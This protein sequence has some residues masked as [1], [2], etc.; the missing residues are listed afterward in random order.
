MIL[1]IRKPVKIERPDLLQHLQFFIQNHAEVS[2][3]N[4]LY[5]DEDDRDVSNS[6]SR[7]S[8]R[9]LIQLNLIEE[10]GI[11]K[12]A[13]LPSTARTETATIRALREMRLNRKAV[14]P[15]P[16]LKVLLCGCYNIQHHFS[17]LSLELLQTIVYYVAGIKPISQKK[18]SWLGA[19]LGSSFASFSRKQ[20]QASEDRETIVTVLNQSKGVHSSSSNHRPCLKSLQSAPQIIIDESKEDKKPYQGNT[21]EKDSPMTFHSPIGSKK[22]TNL[23]SLAPNLSLRNRNKNL[24]SDSLIDLTDENDQPDFQEF[25]STNLKILVQ[26]SKS[27]TDSSKRKTSNSKSKNC[28]KKSKTK[29]SKKL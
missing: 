28:K 13:K 16:I 14:V 6:F 18:V 21:N 24:S 29:S 4:F 10:V 17:S 26:D 22:Q 12:N 15:W 9:E 20:Q 1:L 27:E 19:S 5:T 3:N 2:L 23:I 7:K 11:H 8:F 25:Q